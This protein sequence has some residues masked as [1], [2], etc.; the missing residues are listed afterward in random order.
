[1]KE[2]RLPLG[3]FVFIFDDRESGGSLISDED[4]GAEHTERTAKE[5]R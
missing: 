4:C 3:A 5:G 2:H 1:M